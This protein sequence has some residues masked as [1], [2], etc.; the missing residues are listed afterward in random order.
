V[1]QSKAVGLDKSEFK[2]V[3][4]IFRMIPDVHAHVNC[5]LCEGVQAA[6]CGSVVVQEMA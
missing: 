4:C 6:N 1:Q 5:R 3:A 2:G